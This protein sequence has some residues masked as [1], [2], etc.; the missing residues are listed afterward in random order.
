MAAEDRV[1][2]LDM[3]IPERTAP[4]LASVDVEECLL[5][6]L[7]SVYMELVELLDIAESRLESTSGPAQY[8]P[9]RREKSRM[10]PVLEGS[11]GYGRAFD[12]KEN[13]SAGMLE[14]VPSSGNIIES[15]ER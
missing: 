11:S 4:W 15:S 1:G 7:R 6:M 13:T 8:I 5:L 2:G 3:G 12:D 9:R 14:T 10:G